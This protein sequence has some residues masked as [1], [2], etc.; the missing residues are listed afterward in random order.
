M[1]LMHTT[2]DQKIL[3]SVSHWSRILFWTS[4]HQGQPSLKKWVAGISL[5]KHAGLSTSRCCG[6]EIYICVCARVHTFVHVLCV[7]EK[8][9]LSRVIAWLLR[10][11]NQAGQDQV[12]LLCGASSNGHMCSFRQP[13]GVGLALDPIMIVL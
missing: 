1:W 12:S 5:G 8:R 9:W 3:G 10:L 6:I 13:S 7:G 4:W 2:S 11:V